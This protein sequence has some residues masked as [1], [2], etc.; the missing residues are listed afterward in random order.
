[1][2]N[3]V[4]MVGSEVINARHSSHLTTVAPTTKPFATNHTIDFDSVFTVAIAFLFCRGRN[5]GSNRLSGTIPE[6]M[7]HS[8]IMS[9]LYVCWL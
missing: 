7:G 8:F 9:T 4:M 1:M 6:H 5:L 2:Y 3:R